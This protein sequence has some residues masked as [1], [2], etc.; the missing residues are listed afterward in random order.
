MDDSRLFGKY[1]ILY[2]SYNLL[3][4][5]NNIKMSIFSDKLSQRLQ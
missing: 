3:G 5:E 1:F 2:L 4:G